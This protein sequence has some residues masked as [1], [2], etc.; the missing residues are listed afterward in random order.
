M[1]EYAMKH[2]FP[3]KLLWKL[4]WENY[5]SINSIYFNCSSETNNEPTS[6]E[7]LYGG[8]YDIFPYNKFY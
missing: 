3:E 8:I 7:V 1:S 4:C 2:I 5:L 6:S